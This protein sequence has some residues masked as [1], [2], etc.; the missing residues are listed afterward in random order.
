MIETKCE[1][2]RVAELYTSVH[3]LDDHVPLTF[4]LFYS[5]RVIYLCYGYRHFTRKN[6][7]FSKGSKVSIGLVPFWGGKGLKYGPLA[8]RQDT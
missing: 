4:W 8:T 5:K 2:E 7:L 6:Q 1:I 3:T